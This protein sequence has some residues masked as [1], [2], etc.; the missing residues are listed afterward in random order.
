MFKYLFYIIILFLG[1]SY[2]FQDNN[3]E[4]NKHIGYHFN[5][6]NYIDV[7]HQPKLRKY[8]NETQINKIYLVYDFD[9]LNSKNRI[10]TYL[11]SNNVVSNF[12]NFMS[13]IS[14]VIHHYDSENTKIIVRISSPGGAA[15]QFA[16]LYTSIKRLKKHGFG[17]IAFI[18]DICASGCYMIACAFDKIYATKTSQIGSIGVTVTHTNYNGLL[19]KIGVK[20]KTFG[21]GK[22]K[23]M[24][25]FNGDNNLDHQ[26]DVFEEDLN[27]TLQMFLNIVGSRKKVNLTH[28]KTAKMWYGEDSLKI[29]LIDEIIN[30]DDFLYELSL[31]FGNG[32][33][34]VVSLEKRQQQLNML[35]I[36]KMFF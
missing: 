19:E 10:G 32:I 30:L 1:Y 4:S 2:F 20:E 18:D 25:N 6:I 22:Y 12:E 24:N 33:Y 36:L 23:G 9:T 15:Y 31:D 27:Y 28:V 34:Y 21:T 16:K 13:F 11:N 26:Y 29:G 3:Q 7:H 5:K 17:T 8:Y 14:Y 35:D